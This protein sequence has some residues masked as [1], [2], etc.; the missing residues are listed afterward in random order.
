M[1]GFADCCAMF[2]LYGRGVGQ[3]GSAVKSGPKMARFF[4]V[5]Q[6]VTRGRLRQLGLVN[7]VQ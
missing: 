6:R 5:L 3:G 4:D 1:N 7:P 2:I